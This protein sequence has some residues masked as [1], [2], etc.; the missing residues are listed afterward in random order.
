VHNA[1]DPIQLH[2]DLEDVSFVDAAGVAYL[3]DLR[4]MGVE[5]FGVSPFLTELFDNDSSPDGS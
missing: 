1:P 3:K 4:D 5:L 2:L